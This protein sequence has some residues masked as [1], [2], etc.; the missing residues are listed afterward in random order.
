[1]RASPYRTCIGCRR[2]RPKAELLR[3]ARGVDGG[4][5]VDGRGTAPGRGAY[6]CAAVGCL[7]RALTAGRLAHAF[8][9]AV[10]A[11]R[12]SPGQIMD[13]WRRR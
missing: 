5:V 13:Y 3:L 10:T 11:P 7:E 2:S 4:I 8:K 12:E 9:G 1:V 6:V